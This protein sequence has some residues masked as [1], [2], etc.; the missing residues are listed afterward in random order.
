MLLCQLSK[1]MH[2]ENE[3]ISYTWVRE[4]LWDVCTLAQCD[5]E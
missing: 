4:Y 2:D 5:F 1:D 3:D